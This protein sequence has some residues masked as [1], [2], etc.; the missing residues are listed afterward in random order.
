MILLYA[1]CFQFSVELLHYPIYLIRV[2]VI[3]DASL[4]CL[5]LYLG[6][7]TDTG[8]IDLPQLRLIESAPFHVHG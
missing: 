6:Q 7:L 5:L 1:L 3:G 2:F 8:T 4:A